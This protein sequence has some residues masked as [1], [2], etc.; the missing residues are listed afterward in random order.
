MAN[1]PRNN[2]SFG[3]SA[4]SQEQTFANISQYDFVSVFSSSQIILARASVL[5]SYYAVCSNKGRK[6]I[7][8]F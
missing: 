3:F 1:S 7:V 5:L 6:S 8:H 2:F 4:M